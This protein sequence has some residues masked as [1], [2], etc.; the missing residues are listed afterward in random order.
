LHEFHSLSDLSSP[1]AL[2]SGVPYRARLLLST[3][4]H[5]GAFNSEYLVSASVSANYPINAQLPPVARVSQPFR[6]EFAQSTFANTDADTKYSLLNAPSWLE[7]DSSSLALYGT[8]GESTL[9]ELK[10][11]RL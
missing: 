8:V 7:V 5:D 2:E 1:K 3:S 4:S 6:F 10:S 11:E 9:G